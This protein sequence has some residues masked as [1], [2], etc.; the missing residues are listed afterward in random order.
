MIKKHQYS[1]AAIKLTQPRSDEEWQAQP[2]DAAVALLY[3]HKFIKALFH[4]LSCSS[5]QG[6]RD[7]NR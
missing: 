4:R 3:N 2:R 7:N 1:E 6:D 5:K